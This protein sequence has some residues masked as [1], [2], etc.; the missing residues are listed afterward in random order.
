MP[1][2]ELDM[3]KSELCEFRKTGLSWKPVVERQNGTT[4]FD[5]NGSKRREAVSLENGYG[6]KYSHTTIDARYA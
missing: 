3:T 4:A 5:W 1:E 6:Y 2:L